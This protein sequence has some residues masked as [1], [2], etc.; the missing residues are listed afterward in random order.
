MNVTPFAAEA[1]LWHADRD[2]VRGVTD[3]A[4]RKQ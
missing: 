4:A 1:S 3:D 2:L